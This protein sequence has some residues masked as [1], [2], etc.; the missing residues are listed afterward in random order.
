M[1][2]FRIHEIAFTKIFETNTNDEFA[3]AYVTAKN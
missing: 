3:I 2:Y 1:R